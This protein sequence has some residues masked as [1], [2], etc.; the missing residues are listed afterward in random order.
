MFAAYLGDQN[1]AVGQI[2]LCDFADIESLDADFNSIWSAL[3]MMNASNSLSS[4]KPKCVIFA[5]GDVAFGYGR[6]YQSLAEYED[7]IQ[8]TV[9][10]EEKEAFAVLDLEYLTMQDL[11]EGGGFLAPAPRVTRLKKA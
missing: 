10:R 3:S 6:M 1:Y 9:C 11:R 8:V 7:C 4:K 5:P 2:Q